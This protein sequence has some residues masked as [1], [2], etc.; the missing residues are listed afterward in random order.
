MNEYLI[1]CEQEKTLE[2]RKPDLRDGLVNRR[3]RLEEQL[4]TVNDAIAALDSN[5][6]VAKVLELVGRAGRI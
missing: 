2:C 5:P 1:A 3:N 4:K 6:E